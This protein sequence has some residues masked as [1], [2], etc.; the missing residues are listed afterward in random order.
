[1][2]RMTLRGVR[3]NIDA[4][5]INRSGLGADQR[6]KRR[7][8][9]REYEATGDPI[10]A[11]LLQKQPSS[12]KRHMAAKKPPDCGLPDDARRSRKDYRTPEGF[13]ECG[14]IVGR[15][16]ASRRAEVMERKKEGFPDVLRHPT[17]INI[18]AVALDG[19]LKSETDRARVRLRKAFGG[20]SDGH[21][22]EG[23]FQVVLKAAVEIAA[24]LP[25]D[26][27]PV[28]LDPINRSDE[29][30]AL[31]HW[32]GDVSDP[33]K[34]KSEIRRSL[35]QSFPGSR[36]VCV[37]RVIPERLTKDGYRTAGGQGY[38]EYSCLEKAE[39]NFETR[40]QK[41]SGVLGLA[42]LGETWNRR[43]RGFSMGKPLSVSGVQIDPDRVAKLELN[44]RLEHVK[45]NW[46]K[47]G[48]AEQFIH[49]WFSGLV[50]V[51]KTDPL[52]TRMGSSLSERLK[53]AMLTAKNWLHH[54][55]DEG[56]DFMEFCETQL[57]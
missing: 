54:T 56:I 41:K 42:R 35:K 15:S 44:E 55:T 23:N 51:V 10:L 13:N 53:L 26:E 6:L 4:S 32:H 17:T 1:M 48:A 52:W 28:E 39:I 2:A 57:E 7:I 37:R 20:L 8:I 33:W 9:Q 24:M 27:L 14:S 25:A 19:C 40:E 21:Q 45:K 49:L 47:L 5:N 3:D 22:I 16:Y 18:S 12:E 34:A 43:N 38:L 31:L 46:D 30:F 36:R 11:A 50:K 29:V